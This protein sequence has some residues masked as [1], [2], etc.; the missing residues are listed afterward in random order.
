MWTCWKALILTL[1][2]VMI[3]CNC[4]NDW[5]YSLLVFQWSFW[6]I[7][8]IV[9]RLLLQH[10]K[11]YEK[12][13]VVFLKMIMMPS[14]PY[15]ILSTPLSL[16]MWTYFS[17]LAFAWG[18]VRSKLGGVD[19]SILHHAFMLI[20]IAFWVVILLVVPYLCLFSLILHGLFE[21]EEYRQLE[22]WTG[23]GASLSPLFCATPNALK[24]NMEFFG[25]I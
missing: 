22:F 18:Q 23:K 1:S 9:N 15:F 19:T 10:K 13:Y 3:N 7:L 6:F 17:I 8:Y 12:I 2:D 21:E 25:N 11:S 20:F 16:N 5:D 24:I 14:C 4:F